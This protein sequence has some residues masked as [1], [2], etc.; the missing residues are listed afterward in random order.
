MSTRLVLLLS[1]FI[2]LFC[3]SA[4]CG[5][6]FDATEAVSA[7]EVGAVVVVMMVAVVALW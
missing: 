7:V 5:G 1:A 3:L 6:V 2:I 4:L